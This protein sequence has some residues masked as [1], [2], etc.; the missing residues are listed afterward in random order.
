MVVMVKLTQNI[1][2]FWGQKKCYQ[3]G[4]WN[5]IRRDQKKINGGMKSGETK[6]NHGGMNGEKYVI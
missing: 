1:E 3:V 5:E 4:F 6:K 2:R